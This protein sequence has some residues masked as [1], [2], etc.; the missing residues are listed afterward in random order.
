MQVVA[1]RLHEILD[2]LIIY[3]FAFL[4]IEEQKLKQQ[5]TVADI[6]AAHDVTDD[7]EAPIIVILQQQKKNKCQHIKKG[8]DF[9]Y[10][11]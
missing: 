7:A 4:T 6:F 10:L 8:Q 11:V 9:G 1:E 2:S 5:N 3:Y